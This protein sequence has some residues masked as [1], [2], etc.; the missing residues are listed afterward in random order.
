[1]FENKKWVK[2]G[3]FAKLSRADPNISY[4]LSFELG[5][6]SRNMTEARAY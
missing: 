5:P 3:E 1:M 4:G 2:K 6:K